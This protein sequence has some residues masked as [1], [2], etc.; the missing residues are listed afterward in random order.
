MKKQLLLIVMAMYICSCSDVQE[1]RPAFQS[2]LDGEFLKANE[3]I[4]TKRNEGSYTI[5]GITNTDVIT[6]KVQRS[7]ENTTY[8]LGGNSLSFAN[9][10]DENGNVYSTNP[11]GWGEVTISRKNT[12]ARFF[13][14]NFHFTAIRPG[15]DTI[16]VDRG[17]FFE[18]PYDLN[19][20]SGEDDPSESE[21]FIAQV[22][23]NP[24]NPFDV[25]GSKNGTNI[26]IRGT[27]SSK[28]MRIRVPDD[29][30]NGSH[31]IPELGILLSYEDGGNEQIAESG[32]L[33]IIEHNVG[34]RIIKGTFDFETSSY[35]I[36][37]GQFNVNY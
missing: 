8:V 22:G 27:T 1:N 29:I 23:N 13:N 12:G 32:H 3:A 33:Q 7:R 5:Q 37:Q 10:E 21:L 14:G 28:E 17:V 15:L 30:A 25:I 19:S 35:S 6:L 11:G 2:S 20:T 24:F 34:A 9:Y 36:T 16:V 31:T 18:V 26:V 4:A